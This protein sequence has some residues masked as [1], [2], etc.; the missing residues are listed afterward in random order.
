[1]CFLLIVNFRNNDL[2]SRL[3]NQFA[4]NL[5][6][7]KDI[8]NVLDKLPNAVIISDRKGLSYLNNSAKSILNIKKQD[9]AF[10][11]DTLDKN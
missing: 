4:F 5:S 1:M 7:Q 10:V 9:D 11:E 8:I 2:Q 6:D 3:I